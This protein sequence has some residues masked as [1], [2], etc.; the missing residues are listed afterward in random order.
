MSAPF[1][2]PDIIVP[3]TRVLAFVLDGIVVGELGFGLIA[4]CQLRIWTAM[5]AIA[6]AVVV[7]FIGLALRAALQ[8]VFS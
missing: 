3:L 5:S 6:G 7:D 2:Q 8:A 4:I 1:A